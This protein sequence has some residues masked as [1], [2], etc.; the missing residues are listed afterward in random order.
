MQRRNPV[1]D[2]APIT[3]PPRAAP[4]RT[5]PPKG[6][7]PLPRTARSSRRRPPLRILCAPDSFK[8]S[9]GAFEAAEAMAEG[10]LQAARECGLRVEACPIPMAD[11]GEGTL[12]V[13]LGALPGAL[14]CTASVRGPL[15]E[16]RRARWGLIDGG[17][18]AIVEMAQAAGLTLVAPER[19]TPMRT[20]TAGVGD[21]IR[22]ALACSDVRR[23]LVGVGGSATC[24][25]GLGM[26][27]AL[28]V[29]LLD[30]RGRSLPSPATGSMLGRLGGL[31]FSDVPLARLRE[32]KIEVATDV[33]NPLL[34]PLG[35]ARMFAP[36]K[37]ATARDVGRLEEGLGRLVELWEAASGRRDMAT[38]AGGG[39]AGGLG[40]GLVAFFGARIVPGIECVLDAVRFDQ[41]LEGAHWVMTGEGGL[42]AQSLMGKVLTGLAARA[43][44][45]GVPVTAIAGSVLEAPDAEALRRAG[46]GSA[47]SIVDGPCSEDEAMRDARGLLSRAAHRAAVLFFQGVILHETKQP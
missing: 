40:A 24:D 39:A 45:R 15:G 11:G 44:K 29:R 20:T 25:G 34:G 31:D 27:Q 4:S 41:A 21:L 28:G 36:Q 43:R 13:L 35:A 17:R 22:E 14:E 26:A 47:F 12:D 9:L 42:N 8:G 33:R 18:T 5:A 7:S 46:V 16:K 23:I 10:V 37:G 30:E 32:V 38:L 2:S 19:R 3:P 6:P 1:D